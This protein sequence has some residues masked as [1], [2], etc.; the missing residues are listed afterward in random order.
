MSRVL[1]KVLNIHTPFLTSQTNKENNLTHHLRQ[2]TSI[3][4]II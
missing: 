1:S 4:C 2:N 3:T